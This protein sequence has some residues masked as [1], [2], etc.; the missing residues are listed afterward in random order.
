MTLEGVA[1]GVTSSVENRHEKQSRGKC[2]RK[3]CPLEAADDSDYCP[4]HRDE[5]RDYNREYMARVR[6]YRLKQKLCTWCGDKLPKSEFPK[7][8]AKTA[9]CKACRIR[10][11]RMTT[12]GVKASV[13]NRRERVAARIVDVVDSSDGYARTRMKGGKRGAP[14]AAQTDSADLQDL[15]LYVE[16]ASQGLVLAASEEVQSLPRIQRDEAKNAAMAWVSLLVRAGVEMLK[17]KRCPDPL[18]READHPEIGDSSQKTR[19]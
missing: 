6:A 1:T 7:P 14:K 11:D 12:G 19:R 2:V 4:G 18:A 13:E 9:S 15:R 10:R 3:R 16:K 8:G 5:Q 17:R